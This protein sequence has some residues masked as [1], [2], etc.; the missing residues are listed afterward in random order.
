MNNPGLRCNNQNNNNERS[1][2]NINDKQNDP[3]LGAPI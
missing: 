3:P 1:L 2:K